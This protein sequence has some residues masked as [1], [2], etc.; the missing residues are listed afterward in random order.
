MTADIA[1]VGAGVF[2]AWTALTLRRR[3]A[4]V[5]LYDAYGAGHSRSS[6][7]GETRLIRAGY[8]LDEI[9]TRMTMESLEEWKAFG[10]GIFLPTGMLLMGRANDRRL[11]ETAATLERC[12][13]PFEDLDAAELTRRYPQ[14]SFPEDGRGILET[15]AGALMARRGVQ[16]VVE[17]AIRE[18]VEFRIERVRPGSINT[19]VTVYACGPWLPKLFPNLLGSRIFVTRQ[20]IFF[21]GCP[22]GDTR[23]AGSAMPAWLDAENFYGTP[24]IENRGFKAGRD[25]HGPAVD[26]D[27][28]P[29]FTTAEEL[30]RVRAFVARRFPALA[31]APVI[32][33]RVCQYEN[34]SNGD[35]L[36][37]RHPEFDNVWLVG[38][39]SGHGF[40][41]GPAVG[42]YVADRIEG[43]GTPELRFSLT[44]KATVQHRAVY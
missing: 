36:M 17:Q 4:R 28:E 32:E 29:R 3:G 15:S 6:S 7:G 5:A 41:H 39:G 22:P 42:R 8:A 18:G 31:G 33:T 34:T 12:G 1:V 40:K 19:A 37:D 24:D 2:G 13:V 21:F 30:A 35:F 23:F 20:E 26:P 11:V 25:V 27:T 9:Y 43:I 14:I 10:Q 16:A 44:S 38:G